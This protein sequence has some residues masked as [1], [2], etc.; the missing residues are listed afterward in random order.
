MIA[1]ELRRL[2][3]WP[4]HGS[5]P[6]RNGLGVIGPRAARSAGGPLTE[7]GCSPR[8]NL[9]EEPSV[10][11]AVRNLPTCRVGRVEPSSCRSTGEGSSSPGRGGR[12]GDPETDRGR[13]SPGCGEPPPA[14]F[15]GSG[16]VFAGRWSRTARGTSR[17]GMISHQPLRH[18]LVVGCRIGRGAVDVLGVRRR[19]CW[20]HSP[21]VSAAIA[22]GTLGN[23]LA[24]LTTRTTRNGS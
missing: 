17:S 9:P 21:S 1:P 2:R 20:H 8:V 11:R 18:G 23:R 19:H 24:A 14:F 3:R 13:R 22:S 5:C 4:G 15:A 16:A 10:D 12:G 6:V 7:P